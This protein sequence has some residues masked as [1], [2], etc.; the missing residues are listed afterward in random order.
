MP[1]KDKDKMAIYLCFLQH[2]IY[3]LSPKGKAAVV[4][5]T[6]FLTAQSSIE[7]TIRE[8]LIATKSLRGVISMP[9]NIFAT[10]GTNV[11]VL[12]IDNAAT[13]RKAL[14][15]D[16]S[17]LG[18]KIKEG[19][20]QKTIL[21]AD[22]EARIV[23]EFLRA[24]SVEDFCVSVDFESIAAKN[25]S[26]SAGQ[27]FEVKLSHADIS[28]AEFYAQI[29]GFESELKAHFKRASELEGE[30]LGSLGKLRFGE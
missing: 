4:V 10:T 13:Q 14:L 18:I 25:Y 7:R 22:E 23:R 17:K 26:F 30:I 16:A 3:S 5:P 12:F 15:M 27:Y 29:K 28:E 1:N 21:S 6:G 24:Q 11:S 19:K 8:R 2:I 9:S 20:N